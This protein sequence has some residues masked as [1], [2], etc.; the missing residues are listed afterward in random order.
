MIRK[1]GESEE[2][3]GR[4]RKLDEHVRKICKCLPDGSL[5]LVLGTSADLTDVGNL[6]VRRRN[7]AGGKGAGMPWNSEDD[8]KLQ[9]AVEFARNGVLCL[10]LKG[11]DEGD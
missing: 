4:Q 10:Y 11:S 8:K 3:G 9:N 7:A 2:L 6:R 5:A 1:A